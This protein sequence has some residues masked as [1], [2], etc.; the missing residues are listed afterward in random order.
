M[1]S[2]DVGELLPGNEGVPLV[3]PIPA[4]VEH[5]LMQE[6]GPPYEIWKFGPFDLG[7]M[8]VADGI[9]AVQAFTGKIKVQMKIIPKNVYTHTRDR[10]QWTG[11][12]VSIRGFDFN[13][14]IVLDHKI[15][16]IN[17]SCPMSGE[18]YKKQEGQAETSDIAKMELVWSSSRMWSC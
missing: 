18:Y 2:N 12:N 7:P 13:G 5:E 1:N 17:Q 14:L 3:G 9:V 11:P 15:G 6:D 4:G 10:K 8:T 16:Q